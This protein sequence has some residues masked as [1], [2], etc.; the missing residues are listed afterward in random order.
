MTT[1]PDLY[2]IIAEGHHGLDEHTTQIVTG[3][4]Q[5]V[6]ALDAANAEAETAGIPVRYRLYQLA[7]VNDDA[8]WD[9]GHQ[10]PGGSVMQYVN[11]RA[12]RNCAHHG[13]TLVR[14][15][16]GSSEWSPTR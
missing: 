9:W 7:E 10:F 13:V 16:A 15:R 2:A 8:M 4:T 1:A 12:A 3:R 11:E 5:A 14:R 6:E